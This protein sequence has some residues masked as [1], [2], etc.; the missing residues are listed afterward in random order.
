M[1]ITDLIRE[2]E[3]LYVRYGDV[4]LYYIDDPVTMVCENFEP[5]LMYLPEIDAVAINLSGRAL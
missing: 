3:H 2:L 4:K 5:Q 1:T